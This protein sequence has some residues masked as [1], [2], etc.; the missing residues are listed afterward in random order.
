[1]KQKPSNFA[2]NSCAKLEY[3]TKGMHMFL[4]A[5]DRANPAHTN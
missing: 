1:M 2:V 3:I 5:E 4:V